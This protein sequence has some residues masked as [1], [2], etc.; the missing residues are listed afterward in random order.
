MS[1]ILSRGGIS[2]AY[3]EHV[4]GMG[5]FLLYRQMA[6]PPVLLEPSLACVL[7]SR[8]ERGVRLCPTPHGQTPAL[9]MRSDSLRGQP[10]HEVVRP[11]RQ[12]QARQAREYAA[13]HGQREMKRVVPIGHAGSYRLVNPVIGLRKAVDGCSPA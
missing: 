4:V 7:K 10:L 13:T 9:H 2:P 8:H 3:G 12:R 6:S 11:H 5:P 1:T